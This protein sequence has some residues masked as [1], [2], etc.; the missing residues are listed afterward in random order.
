M[1]RIPQEELFCDEFHLVDLREFS[2]CARVVKGADHVFNLAADMGGMGFIQSN[3]SVI[4]YNNTMISFNMLEA[5]RQEGIQRYFYASSACIYPEN[6][7]LETEIEGG[8]LKEDT[9]WPAQVWWVCL[10][11]V[12]GGRTETACSHGSGWNPH[13]AGLGME[14]LR[15]TRC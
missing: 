7:Q 10:G 11:V 2:A 14:V 9:A 5:A 8:G 3:H 13:R 1:Q 4:F 12:W 6:R 15:R